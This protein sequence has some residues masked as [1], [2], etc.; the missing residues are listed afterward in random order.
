MALSDYVNVL[1]NRIENV[2]SID[3]LNNLKAVIEDLFL[4]ETTSL[5]KIIEKMTPLVDL[6]AILKQIQETTQNAQNT[7]TSLQS[8]ETSLIESIVDKAKE[9]TE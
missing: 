8:M 6:V 2:E 9:L 5:S 7:L 1:K 3:E 4:K